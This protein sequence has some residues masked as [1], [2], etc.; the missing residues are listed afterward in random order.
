ML[1]NVAMILNH[2]RLSRS[3]HSLRSTLNL[4]Q[5]YRAT[6]QIGAFQ[7][8][9][10]QTL[11]QVMFTSLHQPQFWTGLG[12][13]VLDH[14][15]QWAAQ[16]EPPK[17]CLTPGLLPLLPAQGKASFA[18]RE[19]VVIQAMALEAA[20][21]LVAALPMASLEL[22][23]LETLLGLADPLVEDSS[24]VDPVGF[25]TV[26][27]G[28]PMVPTRLMPIEVGGPDPD[29]VSRRLPQV[30][31]RLVRQDPR[32]ISGHRVLGQWTWAMTQR[33]GLEMGAIA[34]AL[35]AR[36]A[37]TPNPWH[38]PI[39]L[40][41]EAMLRRLGWP[42]PKRLK[43]LARL[44]QVMAAASLSLE[45]QDLGD[46]SVRIAQSPLWL[47]ESMVL[48]RSLG[49]RTA[50]E[51]IEYERG[52]V[53]SLRAML[54]PG[55]WVQQLRGV[56]GDEG[57]GLAQAGALAQQ[58]LRVPLR[59]PLAARL[60]IFLWAQDHA[61]AQSTWT[62][63]ALLRALEA[64]EGMRSLHSF[65][66]QQLFE[67]W[68]RALLLLLELGWGVEFE[69]ASYPVALRPRAGAELSPALFRAWLEARLVIRLRAKPETGS[70]GMG[71][72][73]MGDLALKGQGSQPTTQSTTQERTGHAYG[74]SRSRPISGEGL[75]RALAARGMSQAKLARCLGVDRSTVSRWV[76]G[77][78]PIQGR[79]RTLLWDLLGDEL[80]RL[81]ADE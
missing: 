61:Q 67:D 59:E 81:R 23:T 60:A 19:S 10:I 1:A 33:F 17:V 49:G 14:L 50:H 12:G 9:V 73:E 65:R 31:V 7:R 66:R 37:T 29:P 77:E 48:G 38:D 34:L 43:K 20:Q 44:L 54:R 40:E 6:E 79:Y 13:W 15:A 70:A 2:H 16:G 51:S 30:T 64:L 72:A 47:L 52:R 3:P 53:R 5:L 11:A 56:Y 75:A 39:E 42:S 76:R 63:G 80:R 71:S 45:I 57:L 26:A 36:A 4:V 41:G 8:R 35:A 68:N 21:Q 32:V 18:W 22:E 69:A 25:E 55:D 78:R 46:R 24:T 28:L 27:L 74:R 62:V 58:V